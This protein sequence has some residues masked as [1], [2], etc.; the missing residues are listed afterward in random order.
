MYF[1]GGSVS[2]SRGAFELRALRGGGLAW[3]V[4]RRERD[5]FRI[6][7]CFTRSWRTR[8]TNPPGW[9]GLAWLVMRRER[10]AFRIA[11]GNTKAK[12]IRITNNKEG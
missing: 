6:A 4:M 3:L 1:Q 8:A 7:V 12:S 10:E 9:G 11:L 2:Q 5:A